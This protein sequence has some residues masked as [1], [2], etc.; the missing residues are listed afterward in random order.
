MLQQEG[1]SETGSFVVIRDLNHLAQSVFSV[2]CAVILAALA[3]KARSVSILTGRRLMHRFI[4]KCVGTMLD[5]SR[6]SAKHLKGCKL[7]CK[8]L[9]CPHADAALARECNS[10]GVRSSLPDLTLEKR[11]DCK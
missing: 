1:S 9:W 7:K 5:D 4:R 2:H 8:H 3:V 6:K 10:H 11:N